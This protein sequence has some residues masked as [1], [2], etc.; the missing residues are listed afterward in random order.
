MIL[1]FYHNTWILNCWAISF[2]PS[3]FTQGLL[4]FLS[5]AFPVMSSP[6]ALDIPMKY[7]I[8]RGTKILCLETW[9]RMQETYSNSPG[10]FVL[11]VC[12][13]CITCGV[14]YISIHGFYHFYP[15]D[16]LPISPGW[17][18]VCVGLSCQM[19]LNHNN[20]ALWSS[21]SLDVAHL[22]M[23]SSTLILSHKWIV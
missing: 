7:I 3:Y 10:F 12:G 1:L 19:K 14:F 21:H 16:S 13:F 9:N 6:F 18:S 22:W 8:L 2:L 11:L 20:Q 23:F 15:S 5:A 17:V 4:R